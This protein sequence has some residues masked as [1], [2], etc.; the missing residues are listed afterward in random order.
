MVDSIA[1]KAVSTDALASMEE[2]LRP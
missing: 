2:S 1:V